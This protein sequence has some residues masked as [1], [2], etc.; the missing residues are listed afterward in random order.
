MIARAQRLAALATLA[1][2]LAAPAGLAHAGANPTGATQTG[3]A[4]TPLETGWHI[5]RPGDTLRG[6]SRRYSGG[7]DRWRQNWKLNPDIVNPDRIEIGQRI[8]LVLER[9]VPEELARITRLSRRVEA[10]PTPIDWEAAFLDALLRGEDAVRTHERSSAAMSFG[11]GS[12]LK[13]TESSLV[14]LRKVGKGLEAVTRDE[15]EI[16]DGQ[17][18]LGNPAVPRDARGIDVLLGTARLSPRP[19]EAGAVATR[20]RKRERAAQLMVYDGVGTVE[21]GG[22]AVEL[23]RGTGTVVE[24]GRAPAPPE[25][26]LPR[27][28]LVLPA[29]GAS[30]DFSNPPFAWQAVP[31]AASYTL[32]LCEDAGC[33]V[34]ERK[35]AG[36]AAPGFTPDSLP[37][38]RFYWRVTA[39]SPSGLDGYPSESRALSVTA[40]RADRQPPATWHSLAGPQAGCGARLALGPGARLDLGAEDPTGIAAWIYALDERAVDRAAFTGAWPAG[41]HVL[42]ATV[43]DRAGNAATLGPLSIVSDPEPPV[44]KVESGEAGLIRDHGRPDRAYQALQGRWRRRPGSGY[45]PPP[46]TVLEWSADGAR[47]LPLAAGSEAVALGDRPRLFLRSPKGDPFAAGAPARLAPDRLLHLTV[48]D[49]ICGV[50][51]VR[52]G[53]GPGA[54]GGSVFWI[55]AVDLLGNVAR[56]EWPLAGLSAAV[57]RP[58]VGP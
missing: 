53:I 48:K 8:R 41:E 27:P 55:E 15:I 4:S 32:E 2:A 57:A 44:I 7:E 25:L 35:V 39:L 3:E 10:K 47:W 56:Q 20:A 6:L 46:G 23:A 14:F 17:A 18:D 49:E 13:V 9:R 58:A 37:V 11:D 31:G 52:F 1:L 40:A 24:E 21:A 19:G 29:A 33:G 22:A 26:L 34:L 51:T 28:E 38:G 43:T 12:E 16:V 36:L 42:Q 54:M 30:F 45:R 5:A 50:E